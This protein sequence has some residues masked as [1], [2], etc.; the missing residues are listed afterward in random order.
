MEKKPLVR[1]VLIGFVIVATAARESGLIENDPWGKFVGLVIAGLYTWGVLRRPGTAK[2]LLPV[3]LIVG[4]SSCSVS[5]AYL[6]ADAD[7]YDAVAP[8]QK[9]YIEH[10]SALSAEQKARRI[11]TL[12]AWKLRIEKNGGKVGGGS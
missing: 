3:F 1:W 9:Q 4:F 11:R 10:D 12:D 7:T 8:A 5:D 2:A 6:K